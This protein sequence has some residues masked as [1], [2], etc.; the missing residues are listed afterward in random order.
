MIAIAEIALLQPSTTSLTTGGSLSV[1]SLY[2]A[3]GVTERNERTG[4]GDF[5]RI[6]GGAGVIRVRRDRVRHRA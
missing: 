6:F 5:L 2:L 1:N 4:D 3:E